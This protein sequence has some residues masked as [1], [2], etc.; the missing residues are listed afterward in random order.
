MRVYEDGI[1]GQ[2]WK[3]L[4]QKCQESSMQISKKGPHKL[5]FDFLGAFWRDQGSYQAKE[6]ACANLSL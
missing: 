1:K 2:T 6:E 3:E 5:K 4:L